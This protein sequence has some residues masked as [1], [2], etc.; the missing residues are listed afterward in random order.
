[1]ESK[2]RTWIWSTIIRRI[3]LTTLVVKPLRSLNR[4]APWNGRARRGT[5][6]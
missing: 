1:M 3:P 6:F 5:T 2:Q 4:K